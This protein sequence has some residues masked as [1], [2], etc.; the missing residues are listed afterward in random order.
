MEGSEKILWQQPYN[1]SLEAA[2]PCDGEI[3]VTENFLLLLESGQTKKEIPLAGLKDFYV[4]Q[5][6]GSG[7]L[8]AKSDAGDFCICHFD[9]S[10]FPSFG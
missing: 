10:L 7:Y 3:R 4:K 6:V 9:M 2:V 5:E 8:A 1:L